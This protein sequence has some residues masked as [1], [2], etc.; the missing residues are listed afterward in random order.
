MKRTPFHCKTRV[1]ITSN[2]SKPEVGVCSVLVLFL[3]IFTFSRSLYFYLYYYVKLI[4]P[5]LIFRVF[6][7]SK[8][9]TNTISL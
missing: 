4:G 5:L 1:I 6:K 3:C 9:K 7:G 2:Y 8:C